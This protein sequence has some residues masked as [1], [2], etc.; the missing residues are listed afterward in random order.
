MKK[1]RIVLKQAVLVFIVVT[2][3][4]S[5]AKG[6][7]P[8]EISSCYH[9]LLA[10]LIERLSKEGFDLEFLSKLFMDPRAEL[11]PELMTI[12]LV[13]RETTDVYA[14]FLAPEAIRLAKQFLQ[15]NIKT[16]GEIENTFHV[17]KEVIVAILLVESR[18][19]EN[20][21]KRRVV[22]TLASIALIA[23]PEN[24][25]TH[26]HFLPGVDPEI[27]YELLE[28]MAK[29]RAEWAYQELKCFLEIVRN[30]KIDPL[31]VKGSYAG[32]LGWAQFLPSSYRTY[33][34][35]SK[36]FEEWLS[37]KEGA[38][39]SIANY[40]KANGWKEGLSVERKKRVIWSYNHSEP[41]VET[42]LRVAQKLRPEPPRPPRQN[43]GKAPP[44]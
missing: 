32:A 9:P 33:S 29:R 35:S 44:K 11:M 30:E 10:G 5:M 4:F 13:S 6:Y 40:L 25:Q 43:S 26:Y 24:L 28:G 16:L 17:D 22:P 7:P 36:S 41:Y 8:D 34:L 27:S 15:K 20:T 21:G 23:S 2:L 12:S 19:G 39:L 14:P 37:S 1:W 18:F 31:E 38:M 3:P 42:I